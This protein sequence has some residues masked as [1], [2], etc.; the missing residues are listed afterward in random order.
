[1]IQEKQKDL[2]DRRVHKSI[3][4]HKDWLLSDHV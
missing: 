1:M 3:L 4:E 2:I